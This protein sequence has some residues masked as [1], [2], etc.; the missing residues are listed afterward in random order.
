MRFELAM[1][2]EELVRDRD[3]DRIRALGV[4][5]DELDTLST[6][7]VA[8]METDAGSRTS[9]GEVVLAPVLHLLGELHYSS[10]GE[11]VRVV[12]R[13][14]QDAT[15]YVDLR[16]FQR[17]IENLLR[18]AC[19]YA[20][21]LVVVEVWVAEDTVAVEV[22]DDGPGIPPEQRTSGARAVRP[23]RRGADQGPSGPGA[24]PGDRPAHRRCPRRQHHGDERRRGRYVRPHRV[25]ARAPS[26][27][28]NRAA[29][30]RRG[31]GRAHS[32]AGVRSVQDVESV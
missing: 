14:P 18:N 1:L 23:C 24:G 8:W 17:A 7:L 6:D 32:I 27:F 12:V 28:A 11:C 25:A 2:E 26:A 22:R 13:A 15:A 10:A 5:L 16:Q 20:H 31:K 4:D 29:E 30:T 19:R 9:R 21:A 3:L